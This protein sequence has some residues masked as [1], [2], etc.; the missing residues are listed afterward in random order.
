MPIVV[1]LLL[2]PA[3]AVAGWYFSRGNRDLARQG[4]RTICGV[5]IVGLAACVLTGMHHGNATAGEI[6]RRLAHGLMILAWMGVPLS[7]GAWLERNFSER[8]FRAIGGTLVLL[9]LLG[10]VL[11]AS[12]TG[13]L[14]PSHTN[15]LSEE[16]HN[17]WRVSHLFALPGLVFALA[18]AW[19]WMFR[20]EAGPDRGG[21]PAVERSAA[22][23]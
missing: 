10:L 6:H 7:I 15:M 21:S 18:A 2:F 3:F 9:A 23:R 8:P 22:R 19:W 16:T 5:V 17:R 12:F 20:R 14:G 13:Y 1:R 11:F 4:A